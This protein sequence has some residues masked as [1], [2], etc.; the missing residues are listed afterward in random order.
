MYPFFFVR[1][2]LPDFVFSRIRKANLF[3]KNVPKEQLLL[4]KEARLVATVVG[5]I[6]LTNHQGFIDSL[7]FLGVILVEWSISR[8]ENQSH[9]AYTLE[10][11]LMAREGQISDEMVKCCCSGAP[12]ICNDGTKGKGPQDDRHTSMMFA[13]IMYNRQDVYEHPPLARCH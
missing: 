4:G 10:G 6:F 13:Q 1:L 9:H 7:F 3:A 11:L 2:K 12:M 5:L 8:V